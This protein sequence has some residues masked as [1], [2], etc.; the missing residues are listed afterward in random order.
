MLVLCL[1]SCA[2]QLLAP[3]PRAIRGFCL[4][5]P[6]SGSQGTQEAS[7]SRGELGGKPDAG[8]GSWEDFLL[9]GPGHFFQ[10]S[11]EQ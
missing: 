7:S 9:E 3:D 10:P 1:V 8:V 2:L 11:L 5:L 6:V 4:A